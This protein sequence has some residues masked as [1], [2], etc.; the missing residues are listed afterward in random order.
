M[1]LA[2]PDEEVVL[3]RGKLQGETARRFPGYCYEE[4]L[5]NKTPISFVKP[6]EPGACRHCGCL[7]VTCNWLFD[8]RD[9]DDCC[10]DCDHKPVPVEPELIETI[11][12]V[13]YELSLGRMDPATWTRQLVLRIMPSPFAPPREPRV[14]MTN[15]VSMSLFRCGSPADEKRLID[16]FVWDMERRINIPIRERM[17]RAA[18]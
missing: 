15:N 13:D 18:S 12:V 4:F 17:T 6:P 7:K 5:P 16:A 10:F 1:R 14:V 9:A 3:G 8:N 2:T 11:N